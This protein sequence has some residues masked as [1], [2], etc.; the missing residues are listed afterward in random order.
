MGGRSSKSNMASS[1]N[2]EP[3]YSMQL[4]TRQTRAVNLAK[5]Q[6]NFDKG[7]TEITSNRWSNV[8]MSNQSMVDALNASSNL[9]SY[10]YRV[11]TER[12]NTWTNQAPIT[13]HRIYRSRK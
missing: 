13:H 10:E 5:R 1:T 2:E 4:S 3:I 11:E 9:Y 6:L 8:G 7:Y 12:G